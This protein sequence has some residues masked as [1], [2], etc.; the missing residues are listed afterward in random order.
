MEA[1]SSTSTTVV[2]QVEPPAPVTS[3]DMD[4]LEPVAAIARAVGP[5]VVQIETSFGVGSGVIYDSSG[6]ILTAAHVVEG[7]TE[8]IV[9]FSN[10]TAIEGTV[11]GTHEP[12]DVAVVSI[13]GSPDLPTAVLAI[14]IDPS[15]GSLAVALGSPFGLDQTVTAG[16]VSAVRT[17]GG[18]GMVQTDAAINPGNSGGPLVDRLGRVIGINDQILTR[19]GASQ[20]VGFA[21]A[22]DIAVLVADQLVA[23]EEVRLARLG[24]SSTTMTDGVAGALVQEVVEDSAAAAAGLQIGDLIVAI[25]GRPIRSSGDLRAEII[26]L[27]PGTPVTLTVVRDGVEITV[28]AVLGSATF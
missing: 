15:I 25:G 3:L 8:V 5:A 18:V 28:R 23:G 19:S 6:L 21:I 1:S 24:V 26:S 17:I 27:S 20:G 14:G 9:R 2:S 22:I 16:V 7:V 4:G 10:G 13:P 11:V 12:T